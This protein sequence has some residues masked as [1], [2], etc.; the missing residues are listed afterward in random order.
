M[1]ITFGVRGRNNRS[2]EVSN[3]KDLNAVKIILRTLV[4][5]WCFGDALLPVYIK[6]IYRFIFT[7]MCKFPEIAPRNKV[8]VFI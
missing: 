6:D 8:L 2:P 4:F 7:V 3:P 1:H 5:Y